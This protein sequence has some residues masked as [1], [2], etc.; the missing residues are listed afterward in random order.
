[1]G[2]RYEWGRHNPFQDLLVKAMLFNADVASEKSKKGVA[3]AFSFI[4]RNFLE[5]EGDV[6]YLDFEITDEDGYVKVTGNNSITALWLSGMIPDDT[7]L[8]LKHN[9]VIIGNRK[10]VYNT[11]TRK[12]TFTVIKN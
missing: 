4:L 11:K 8:I 6:V 5:Y 1:M 3:D 2:S 10:Y 12:L 9:R 7:A